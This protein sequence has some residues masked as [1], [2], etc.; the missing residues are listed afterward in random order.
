MNKFLLIFAFL[1]V[2]LGYSQSNFIVYFDSNKNDLN[3]KE[4]NKLD[5]WIIENPKVKIISINGYTDEDG[6]YAFNDS[7]ALKRVSSIYDIVKVRINTRSDFKMRSFGEKHNQSAD[8]SLNRKVILYYLEE[9]ELHLENE[10]LGIKPLEEIVKPKI[11]YPEVIIIQNPNGTKSEFS[12]DVKFMEKVSE[13]KQGEK[14]KIDN[15]NFH[16]NTF[17]IVNESRGKLYELLIVLQQNPNLEIE[18]QGHL[19][20]MPVDRNNLST[21]RAKAIHGFLVYSGID[22][23][24]LSYKGFGSGNPLYPLPE[25]SEQERA[26]NRRV[27]IEI[28]KN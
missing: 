3:K 18:I 1:T 26:A 15:L 13:S 5:K 25:K 19:C 6:T 16:L 22:K 8:K 17:A 7:L 14:L 2:T 10:I 11:Q 21:Q 20:C 24:R 4:F 12:L 9:K 27:E 23:S 28:V